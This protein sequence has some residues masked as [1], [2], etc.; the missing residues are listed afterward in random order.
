MKN[1][2]PLLLIEQVVLLLVFVF[3]AAVCLRAF[4]WADVRAQENIERDRAMIEVQN[5]VE[6]AKAVRGDW[7]RAAAVYGGAGKEEGWS[8]GYDDEWNRGPENRTFVLRVTEVESG[9][10]LLGLALV[11]LWKGEAL[12]LETQAAWQEVTP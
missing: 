3:A 2:T 8:I 12:L 1:K 9:E 10:P 5:A 11:Q 6:M 4:V 7:M